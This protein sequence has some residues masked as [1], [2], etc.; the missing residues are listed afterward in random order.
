M[1]KFTALEDNTVW[2]CVFALRD[3]DGEVTDIY[4]PEHNPLS[5]ASK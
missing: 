3:L 1:H 2:Y 4:G 5:A